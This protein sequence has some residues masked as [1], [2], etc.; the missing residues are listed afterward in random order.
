M[1]AWVLIIANWCEQFPILTPPICP[2][3][4]Y[5]RFVATGAWRPRIDINARGARRNMFRAALDLLSSSASF[6]TVI[7]AAHTVVWA[8]FVGCILAVWVFAWRADFFH[9]ALSI[10][11]VRCQSACDAI[12]IS[13]FADPHLRRR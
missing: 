6:L 11:V 1:D 5:Y 8:L 13:Q 4:L 12:P 2:C 10:G 9:A 3:Y 7:K